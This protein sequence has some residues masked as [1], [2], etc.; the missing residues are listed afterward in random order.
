MAK[1]RYLASTKKDGLRFRILSR[2]VENPEETDPEKVR[3]R[4][5]LEGSHGITFERV[6]T[7]ASLAKFGYEVIAVD[8]DVSLPPG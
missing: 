5:S 3:M 7:S 8:E 6:V 1:V 2:A 4:L